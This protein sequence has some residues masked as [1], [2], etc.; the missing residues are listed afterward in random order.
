MSVSDW[1]GGVAGTDSDEL[2]VQGDGTVTSTAQSQPSEE[3]AKIRSGKLSA[4]EA[5]AVFQRL[6]D[7]RL[8]EQE[9]GPSGTTGTTLTVSIGGVVD[10]ISVAGRRAE[11]EA[12]LGNVR[13]ALK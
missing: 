4:E 3:G 10:S 2:K 12:L 1:V 9:E 6:K 11:A 8:L 5:K 13:S 7:S